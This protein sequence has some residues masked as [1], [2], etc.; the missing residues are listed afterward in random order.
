[1]KVPT[2]FKTWKML[3]AVQRYPEFRFYS[4]ALQQMPREEWIKLKPEEIQ[5]KIKQIQT[6]KQCFEVKGVPAVSFAARGAPPPPPPPPLPGPPR[7]QS[8]S[9]ERLLWFFE[10]W[11]VSSVG[12]REGVS[13]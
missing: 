11:K 2:F 6:N 1:M 8:P 13:F 5:H 3:S 10:D 4:E 7:G 12:E 9:W